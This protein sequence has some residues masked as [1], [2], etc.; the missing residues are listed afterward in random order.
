MVEF[1]AGMTNALFYIPIIDNNLS[2]SNKNFTI[3][4]DPSSLPNRVTADDQNQA[5]VIIVD[6]DGE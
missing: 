1:A 2:E 3:A 5:V 6:D 4:I